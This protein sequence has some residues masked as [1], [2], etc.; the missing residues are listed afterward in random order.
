ML[1]LEVTTTTSACLIRKTP[2][3]VMEMISGRLN[4]PDIPAVVHVSKWMKVYHAS[5]CVHFVIL[6]SAFLGSK[7]ARQ[8]DIIE[9]YHPGMVS[10]VFK[11]M[12]CNPTSHWS[13]HDVLHAFT[14]QF[15]HDVHPPFSAAS[16][17]FI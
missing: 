6:Q 2:P 8:L 15:C 3:E 4:F 13:T 14:D 12:R 5:Q 10:W 1:A 7:Y 17:K 11:Q 16:S 9:K